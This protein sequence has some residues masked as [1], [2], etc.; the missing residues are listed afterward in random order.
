MA[1]LTGCYLARVVRLVR[2]RR[3][4]T[5]SLSVGVPAGYRVGLKRAILSINKIG[6]A[7]SCG[8]G[9]FSVCL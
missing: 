9:R 4:A 1:L 2:E 7:G 6:E 8:V 3:L 5:R